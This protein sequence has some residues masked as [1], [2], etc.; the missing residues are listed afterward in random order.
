M[1]PF[2]FFVAAGG[3]TAILWLKLHDRQ[4]GVSENEF[5]IGTWLT[6]LGA[7]VGAK[8]LFVILG[9]HHY[10]TGELQF[11]SNFG[12]GFV[13][14]GGLAGALTAGAIFAWWRSL[15]FWRG[16]DYFAVALPLGH[17]IGRIGCFVNGC[18]PGRPPHPVQLYESAGLLAISLICFTVLKRV[19]AP[20]RARGTAF[21]GYL[22][23]YGLLRLLLDPLRAD[24]RP[25][26]LLG[27]SYQQGIAI[28]FMLLAGA[29]A[30]LINGNRR[31]STLA[32]ARNADSGEF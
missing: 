24:G 29:G 14:F 5:W 7:I 26:R 15:S 19:E 4:I 2:G 11:W 12:T 17:A 13:F 8:A 10:A 28:A 9:W 23:L 20:R 27:L 16:T 31:S 22:F 25:E 1:T 3:V 30:L 6:F 18:C 21:C 32:S